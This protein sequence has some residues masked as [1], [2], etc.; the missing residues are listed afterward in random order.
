MHA[1][2]GKKRARNGKSAHP[3]GKTA[4]ETEKPPTR[5][6]K[7]RTRLKKA[8]TRWKNRALEEPRSMANRRSVRPPGR[9]R[10][11]V[12][13]PGCGLR[14]LPSLSP[15]VPSGPESDADADGWRKSRR[16]GYGT[17]SGC[18]PFALVIFTSGGQEND[19]RSLA[20]LGNREN[21]HLSWRNDFPARPIFFDPDQGFGVVIFPL[22]H[23][24]PS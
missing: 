4:H 15:S 3:D 12:S 2:G 10:V 17:K 23:V 5:L 24:G 8:R 21:F 22:E 20:A 13:K 18:E 1:P 11:A 16:E 7:P 6:Q 14:P 19:H 9:E